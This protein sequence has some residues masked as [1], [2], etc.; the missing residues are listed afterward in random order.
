MAED[1]GKRVVDI[2]NEKKDFEQTFR[3][4]A[5]ER[6]KVDGFTFLNEDLMMPVAR[7]EVRNILKASGITV[8]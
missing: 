8:G 2:Y 3:W 1:Y 4:V 7:A 5:R 6:L